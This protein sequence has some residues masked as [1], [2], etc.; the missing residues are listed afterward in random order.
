MRLASGWPSNGRHPLSIGRSHETGRH[1]DNPGITLVLA[2][3][4]FTGVFGG[5]RL[6]GLYALS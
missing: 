2:L 1:L 4:V 5:A 6:F 3:A